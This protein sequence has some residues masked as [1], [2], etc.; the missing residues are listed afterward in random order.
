MNKT[1]TRIRPFIRRHFR[2]VKK[3]FNPGKTRI[4]LSVPTYG[5]EEVEEALESMLSTWV[6]MGKKVRQFEEAF[7]EY[8]GSKHAVM[9]NS[10]SSANLLAMSVLTNPILKGRIKP[11]T[12]VITPAVTWVTTVYPIV[13]VGLKP[14]LV[15]VDLETFNILPDEAERAISPQTSAI[16]PVHLLGS[17]CQIDRLQRIASRHNLFLLEDACESTGAEFHGRKVGTFGDMG[18]FSFFMSH[19]ISTIE[20]GMIVTD[21]DTLFEYLKAGRA[22]GWIREMKGAKRYAAQNPG[23]DPRFLFLTSGYN[24]RPTEIQGAFGVHQIKKLD[25]FIQ[26]RRRNAKYWNS[27]L[28]PYRDK[29]ILPSDKPGTKH[30][31]FGYPITLRPEAKIKRERMVSHLEK[32][33]IETRPIMAGNFADQP[34]MKQLSCRVSGSLANSRIISR[35]SF[36]FGNHSGIRDKER[37]FIGDCLTQFL[38]SVPGR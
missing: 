33:G 32:N 25:S 19:H 22:F 23:I 7:A 38:D 18:T 36:F 34:V 1:L 4:P 15:D 26:H 9:V 21:N 27:R 29:L 24:L 16:I 35:N 20:G 14:V 37:E 12:E 28:R 13:N 6:S 17:P 11:G 30:V 3:E 10:G 8:L 31:F 2:E 5:S